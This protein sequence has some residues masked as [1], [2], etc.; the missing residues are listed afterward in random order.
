ME[1][2]R[3]LAK[4]TTKAVAAVGGPEDGG[5]SSQRRNYLG[6][7]GRAGDD[8]IISLCNQRCEGN[9]PTYMVWQ[10]MLILGWWSG[11]HKIVS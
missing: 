1:M 5:G 3:G 8:V 6:E 11:M 7:E 2:G 9:L 10:V 4:M